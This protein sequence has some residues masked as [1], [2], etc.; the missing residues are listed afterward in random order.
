[1]VVHLFSDAR[2]ALVKCKL[3]WRYFTRHNQAGRGNA[4]G[5]GIPGL[6]LWPV[7]TCPVLAMRP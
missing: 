7:S 6:R 4:L 2:F 1:M 5:S 3:A